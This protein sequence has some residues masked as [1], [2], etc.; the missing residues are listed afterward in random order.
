MS[1]TKKKSGSG[2]ISVEDLIREFKDAYGKEQERLG[3]FNLAIF[4]KTGVGKST[5][6]NTIFSESVARTGNGRPVTEGLDYYPHPSG[7]FGVYDS[8]G[9]E[10]GEKGDA[11][12]DRF[13]SLI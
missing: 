13:R 3:C 9:I 5:L 11:I 10:T 4:G 7:F 12:L 2:D 1:A 8:E 6:V